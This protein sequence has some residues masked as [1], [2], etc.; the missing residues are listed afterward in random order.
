[1]RSL[2]NKSS[3]EDSNSTEPINLLDTGISCELIVIITPF[4]SDSSKILIKTQSRI[5]LLNQIVLWSSRWNP[6][7]SVKSSGRIKYEI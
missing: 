4:S 3:Y 5:S 6:K 2:N 1:M 7:T